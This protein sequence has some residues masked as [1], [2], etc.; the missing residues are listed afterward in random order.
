MTLGAF[1]TVRILAELGRKRLVRFGW[2]GR[3]KLTFKIVIN[4]L[5]VKLSAQLPDMTLHQASATNVADNR[6]T[7]DLLFNSSPVRPVVAINFLGQTSRYRD[8]LQG[9]I[10]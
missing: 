6:G 10:P 2:G 5:S 4:E 3:Q 1:E 8:P 9:Q 7:P